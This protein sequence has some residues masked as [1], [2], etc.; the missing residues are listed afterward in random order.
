MRAFAAPILPVRHGTRAASGIDPGEPLFG[1]EHDGVQQPAILVGLQLHTLAARHLRQFGDG[2]DQ[3]L[4][5]LADNGD[6]VADYRR[7]NHRAALLID[8]QH[9]L[10]RALGGDHLFFGDDEAVALGAG[11]EA[12]GARRQHEERNGLIV[13]AE[14][15][16][17]S[18][19]LALPAPARQLVGAEREGAAIGREQ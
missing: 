3:Q 11:D 15:D 16:L 6:L 17:Q 13:L 1:V 9:L 18:D 8:V 4:A 5:V 10:T 2:E 14:L 12:L 7:G 19:G